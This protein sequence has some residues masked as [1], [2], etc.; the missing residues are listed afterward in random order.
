MC[1][2]HDWILRGGAGGAKSHTPPLGKVSMIDKSKNLTFLVAYTFVRT[3]FC[4]F[5]VVQ[6]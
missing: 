3:F 5:S 2:Y 6:S 1:L 4:S